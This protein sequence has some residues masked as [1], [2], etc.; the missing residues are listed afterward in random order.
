[1]SWLM[2]GRL[3]M[4]QAASCPH[5]DSA[6]IESVTPRLYEKKS[7]WYLCRAC[8]RIWSIPNPPTMPDSASH[9]RA[10]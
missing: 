2:T 5:C 3:K 1:M 4:S 6:Q 8:G 10:S 7:T 9:S